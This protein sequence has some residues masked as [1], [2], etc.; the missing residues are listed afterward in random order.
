LCELR[1]GT[2]G[3][4][5]GHEKSHDETTTPIHWEQACIADNGREL[6]VAIFA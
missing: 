2:I 6:E 1:G 3:L 5:R 4:R